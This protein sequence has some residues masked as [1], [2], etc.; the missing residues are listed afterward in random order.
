MRGVREEGRKCLKRISEVEILEIGKI[1]QPLLDTDALGLASI[2]RGDFNPRVFAILFLFFFGRGGGESLITELVTAVEEVAKEEDDAGLDAVGSEDDSPRDT[3]TWLVLVLPPL[4]GDH[5]SDRVGEEPHGVLGN[6]LGVARGG[7]GEPGER[8]DD[9]WCASELE[10]VE[11]DQESNTTVGKSNQEDCR[12]DTGDVREHRD[13]STCVGELVKD[14]QRSRDGDDH[15]GTRGNVQKS[16]LLDV[17][18]KVFDDQRVLNTDTTDK[19]GKDREEHED[20]NLGIRDSLDELV[21]LPNLGL[22]TGLSRSAPLDGNNLFMLSQETSLCW[23]VG[24]DDNKEESGEESE[25]GN[26]DHEPLPLGD[27]A[28]GSRSIGRSVIDAISDESR[29]DLSKAV[30]LECPADTFTHFQSIVEH[31][32]EKHDSRSNA[33]F[34]DAEKDTK[35]NELVVALGRTVASN[36]QSPQEH[37]R[38]EILGDWEL[39]EGDSVWPLTDEISNVE[40]SSEIVQ[41]GIGELVISKETENGGGTNG[42]LVHE[43]KGVDKHEEGNDSLI[44][45]GFDSS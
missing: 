44:Q 17:E 3:V 36:K 22:N 9:G 24:E 42:V 43:L 19:V 33:T 13:P 6:L 27:L 18:A 41:F 38:G 32:A 14:V 5:L 2:G 35:G 8:N 20:V 10:S 15:D 1:E 23:V 37:L 40:E 30:A 7:G 29:D 31:G 28:R 39:L 25:N 21:P 26:D 12:D 34:G 16:R 11:A 4:R 45:L